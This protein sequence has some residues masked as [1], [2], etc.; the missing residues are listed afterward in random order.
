[1]KCEWTR[2]DDDASYVIEIEG[3]RAYVCNWHRKMVAEAPPDRRTRV[4]VL[5]R[6]VVKWGRS[7]SLN[8]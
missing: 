6:L 3:H 5:D 2:C 7:P 1:M 8:E 4:K